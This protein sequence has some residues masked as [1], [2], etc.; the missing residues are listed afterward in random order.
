MKARI[1]RENKE[2]F[3][4]A[5]SFNAAIGAFDREVEDYKKLHG[6]QIPEHVEINMARRIAK[7]KVYSDS[8]FWEFLHKDKLMSEWDLDPEV[9]RSNLYVRVGEDQDTHVYIKD[10]QNLSAG[11]KKAVM[12]EIA[13][14]GSDDSSRSIAET[15]IRLN[16]GKEIG[17]SDIITNPSGGAVT[18]NQAL[19]KMAE[20]LSPTEM[21]ERA[22][23]VGA[24][25]GTNAK[26]N[27]DMLI[28]KRT[29][30]K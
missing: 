16:P 20:G 15:W 21:E 2:G 3:F 7:D 29:A 5:E 12:N 17:K 22:V 25:Y 30:A 13:R 26:F 11:D 23:S 10:L 24:K 1:D 8:G 28:I 4:D 9:D 14:T 27:W 18:T 19:L 6:G